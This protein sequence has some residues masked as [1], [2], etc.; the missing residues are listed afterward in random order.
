MKKHII[1][2]GLFVVLAA[3][4]SSCK[5]DIDGKYLN[6]EKSTTKSIPGFFTAML[7]NDRVAAKYWNVRTFLSVMP[8]TYA[9]TSYFA[10]SN[11]A[12]QQSDSYSQQYWDDFYAPGGNGSGPMAQYRTIETVYN[13]ASESEKASNT[14]FINAAKVVLIEQA[15]KMVDLWGDIPYSEAGSLVINSTIILPKYDDQKVLYTQFIADLKAANTYFA[16]AATTAEFTKY[17]ILLSGNVKKWQSYTNSLRLRLLMRIS[18]SDEAT[19]KTEI[20]AMLNDPATYPLV[21]GANVGSYSPKATD[22]LLSPLTNNTGTLIDAFREGSWYASDFMLNKVMNPA[23]DPRIPVFYDKGSVTTGGKTVQNAT[24][25][26]MPYDFTAAQQESEFAKYAVVDSATLFQNL[27]LPGIVITASEV[28]FLKAEAQERWGNT[29]AAKTAYDLALRQS[30]AFYYYLNNLN[31]SG[32]K[33]ET[34]PSAETVD[35]F[36]NSSTAAYPA[37]TAARLASIYTQKWVH[38]GITQSTEA[39]SEYRRTGF[40]QLL[41]VTTGKLSGFDVPPN[42]LI[43]PAGEQNYNGTNYSAVAAKDTRLTKIFWDVN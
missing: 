37:T 43:Y 10:N 4:L 22:V 41:F 5:K 9:Q 23:N 25:K 24:Y 42:R 38:Y 26:A 18:N 17:D 6:P 3:S 12:Y 19:A 31:T 34:A 36:V 20:L 7:N 21:D 15:A 1:K 30:V 28:N 11:A 39:W 33:T 8:G 35:T 27:N 16:T 32:V 13:S 14:I 29:A 40:P 2:A